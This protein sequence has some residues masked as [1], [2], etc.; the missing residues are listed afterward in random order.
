[1]DPVVARKTW[2]TIEPVHG[3]IYFTP[4]GPVEYGAIGISNARMGY[5][6]SRVAALGAVSA[7]VVI[8]TFF[9]FNPSL[10]R[11]HVPSV[12]DK[13]S[14]EQV[15]DARHRAVDSSLRRAFGPE[16]LASAELR[17][18]AGLLRTAAEVAMSRPEGRTLFA[19]HAA[20]PWP[21]ETHMILWHAQTLLREFRGDGHIA[22]LVTEG[23]SG[24]EAL[25]SHAASGD[26]SAEVLRSSR[27]WS[28]EE[29][30]AGRLGMVERGLLAATADGAVVFTDEGRAQRDRIE[31]ITDIQSTAPYA[32]LGGERCDRI[33]QI[34]RPFSQMVIDAGLLTI[35]PKRFFAD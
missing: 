34:G 1:M 17:E 22:A 35:D 10:I 9:N 3:M 18:L 20:Q 21:D 8:S 26:V 25:L 32:A 16:G 5:F 23:L 7:E 15:T 31:R 19:A 12:W 27:A 6:A 29:W 33:R 30:E 28:T 13:A 14:P 4:D 24:I 2:R 11:R